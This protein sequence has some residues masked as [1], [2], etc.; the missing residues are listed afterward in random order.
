MKRIKGIEMSHKPAIVIAGAGPAGLVA[1]NMLHRDGFDV[2]VFEA[3]ASV[4]SRDQGGM[5]DLHVPDGQLA[6]KKAGLFDAFMAIARHHDQELRDI[7]WATG[8]VLLEDI[9]APGTGDRPEIDRLVLR[10]LLLT[11][12]P[13]G[14]VV[15]GAR[16][17]R[18]TRTPGGRCAVRLHDGRTHECDLVIG[19]DGAGSAV[20]AALT[21]VRPSYSGVTFVELWMTDVDRRHPAIAKRVGHG[22]LMSL[23]TGQALGTALFAQRNGNA[24][25]RSYAAF[26]TH[27]DDT[28]RPEKALA[29]LT[30]QDLLARFPGWSPTLLTLIEDA[31]RIAAIRPI[32]GLPVGTRWPAT[33]GLTLIGD[34]AH[35]TPPM[36]VGVNLAM[37][38]AAELAQAIASQTDWQAAVH[39]QE[40]AMLDRAAETSAECTSAFREWFGLAS[41]AGLPA[42]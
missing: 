32:V 12:L 5:L 18:V 37:L 38:D 19:A 33:P 4:T 10:E 26:R 21:D 30:K 40:R 25:V 17:A 20:R 8:A 28:D 22:T 6:L 11:P 29:N 3:D 13:A 34:A 16:I 23:G 9:P 2:T 31:D 36:G 1:A 27:A 14:M 24:V 7:D 39:A 41:V 15:W 35:V 42:Q